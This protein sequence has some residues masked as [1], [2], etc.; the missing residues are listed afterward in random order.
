[1]K[2][3]FVLLTLMIFVTALEA[4]EFRYYAQSPKAILMGNAF[5]ALADDEYTLFYNPA[6]LGRNA[7]FTMHVLNPEITITNAL[8]DMDKFEDIPS[9]DPVAITDR[10]IG[11]PVHLGLG[12]APGFKMGSFGLTA[13]ANTHTNFTI[14]NRVHPLLKVDYRYDK[15]FVAGYAYDFIGSKTRKKPRKKG[16]ARSAKGASANLGLSMKY[17]KREGIDNSFPIF[18]PELL[19]KISAADQDWHDIRESL[20]YSQGSSW[21]ADAGFLYSYE[22]RF[23]EFSTGLS[24]M[25]I[26][27]THFKV[28]KGNYKVPRQPMY[29]NWGMAWQQD[30][31]L[32][33]YT[34]SLDLAP[35]NVD[36]PLRR[37]LRVGAS[38]GIPMID[39]YAGLS[40]GYASYGAAVDLWVFKLYAGF[41]GVEMGND[42]KMK[43]SK[44]GVI[45]LSILD[46]SFQP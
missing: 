12:V 4:R 46:M 24:V 26:G 32:F 29:V 16:E 9:N 25:D 22:T 28:I 19:V 3:A 36:E 35:L 18:G 10:F 23:S 21:G 39:L 43:Q 33:N 20:G 41:Y 38:F 42:Y 31:T 17:I 14:E 6:A 1:M 8:A 11:Y 40:E 27:G 13:I 44:R 7:G 5:T 15:G 30:F 2:R 37:K 34:L 45:Y